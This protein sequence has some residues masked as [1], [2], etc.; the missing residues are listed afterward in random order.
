MSAAARQRPQDFLRRLL[1]TPIKNVLKILQ[2]S[3][4]GIEDL[5][6]ARAM[7]ALF[8]NKWNHAVNAQ[9]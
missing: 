3:L 5:L 4:K 8:I 2:Y 1:R 9:C 7:Q 6:M